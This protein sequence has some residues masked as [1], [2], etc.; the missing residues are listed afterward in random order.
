[1]A[2]Q[3]PIPTR[4]QVIS[5]FRE[6]VAERYGVTPFEHQRQYWAAS[7]GLQLLDIPDPQGLAITIPVSNLLPTDQPERFFSVKMAGHEVE[8][9]VTRRM[10]VPRPEGRARFL[11]DLG[12]FKVGKS[13]GAALW[14]TGF[15]MIPGAKVP[16]VGLQYDICEPEFSYLIEFLLSERGM[17]MEFDSCTNNPRN[18]DMFLRLKNGATFE[19]RSWERKDTLKGKEVD[20][21]IYCEAYQLPGIECFT[22][23]SQNLRVREGFALF[24]TTPDRPWVKELKTLSET[25]PEWFCVSGVPAEANPFAFDPKAKARDIKLMTREKYV[26][27]YLGQLGDFVGRVFPFQ[28]GD[29]KFSAG[30]HPDLFIGSTGPENLRIPSN[31]T[32]VGGADTG[33]Y[34]SGLLVAFSVDGDAFVIDEF[35]NYRYVGGQAE[36][37]EDITIPTWTR[38]AVQQAIARGARPTFWADANSQFKHELP[39]YGMTLLPNAATREHRTEVAREYFQHG[40]IY[41]APWLDV[42]PFELESACWPEEVS[43]SGKYERVKSNDHTLDCLEHVLYQRP[44]GKPVKANTT[45][46]QWADQFRRKRTGNIHLGS[47]NPV[48]QATSS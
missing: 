22:S 47:G 18:G 15:A 33:T 37:D 21:Y 44:L 4:N 39:H 42:L 11:A 3:V 17:G 16:L 19:A 23:F 32:I 24:P 48:W 7:D 14:A 34:Y 45:T 41:L 12:A 35:P 40:R 5:L 8:C 20:A 6:R 1:M 27:H 31:W 9:A 2:S 28:R 30:T 43:A 10:A 13:F 46:R 38:G 36:K 26:I 29:R 25:D